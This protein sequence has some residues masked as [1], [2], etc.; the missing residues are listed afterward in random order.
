LPNKPPEPSPTTENLQVIDLIRALAIGGVLALHF[1]L[2]SAAGRPEYHWEEWVWV[3]FARNGLY[4]VFLFFVVSGYLITRMIAKSSPNLL[5]PGL[6][7]FYS[8]RVGRI[9]PLW[10]LIMGFGLLMV[11]VFPASNRHLEFC[12]KN[13]YSLFDRGFWI[14]LCTFT[15]NWYLAFF[16]KTPE[17]MGLHWDVLW[18]LSIEEQFYLFYPLILLILGTKKNLYLFLFSSIP[19]FI[20]LFYLISWQGHPVSSESLSNSFCGFSSIALGSLLYLLSEDFRVFFSTHPRVCRL[21]CLLGG[22]LMTGV[23]FDSSLADPREDVDGPLLIS[24]GLFIFLLGGLFLKGFESRKWRWIASYGKLSYGLYLL[25]TTVLYFLW[26]F[27]IG[28]GMNLG[29]LLFII[30]SGLVAAL[31]YRYFE[32]PLNLKIRSL[33]GPV[34]K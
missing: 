21:L 22:I 30:T 6:T 29:F 15:F 9:F 34:S 14:S 7:Q 1:M 8:R 24:L 32:K 31:S 33:F 2:T 25:H 28:L 17:M 26:P 11:Y 23:Y 12:F 16:Q 5:K 20:S 3:Y 19:V 4:G 18:S 27:F 10:F 13:H